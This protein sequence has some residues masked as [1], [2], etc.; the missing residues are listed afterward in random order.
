M[1]GQGRG[2]VIATGPAHASS[3]ASALSLADA[4]ASRETAA[5][6]AR[7]AR[8]VKLVATF[9]PV[10]AW[11]WRCCTSC[12]AATA[13]GAVLAG[14]TLAMA[15]VPEEFPVVLTVFLALGA[16]RISR[17]GVLT[18]RMPAIEMLGAATVLCVDK[19]GT[20]TENRMTRGR[21]AAGGRSTSA[22]LACELDPF[23]PWTAPS[24]RP[25][26]PAGDDD[27]RHVGAW[28]ATIR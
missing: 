16:W 26:A 11:R 13:L 12:C 7:R 9:A 20:L 23:D 21:D 10:P 17:R 18:R 22:A 19:T 5:R 28:S 14:L 25:P 24:S 1:K 27:Q 2:E 6:S 3:G 4:R 15:I 8:I